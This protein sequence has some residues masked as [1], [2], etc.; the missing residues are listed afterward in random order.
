M[1]EQ[2]AQNIVTEIHHEPTLYAEPIFFIGSFPVTNALLTSW[3]AVA[4]IVIAAVMLRRR[5]ARIPH[6]I[7]NYA[8]VMLEGAL[9]LAD[10]VTTDRR[11]SMQFMPLVFSFFIFILLSNWLGILPGVGSIGFVHNDHGA[12]SLVPLFRGVTADLNTTLALSL[13]AVIATH[14]FG[15]VLVGARHHW[16]RFLN[17]ET[18]LTIPREVFKKKNYTALIVNPINFG[19]GLIEAVGELAKVASLSFRLFGNVFAGE[20]LLGAMAAILAYGLPIPFLMLEILVGL[21]QA[22]IFAMLVLVF[23]TIMSTSHTAEEHS[24]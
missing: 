15:V 13:I 17:V 23:M 1:S 2:V 5:L 16:G 4:I 8:E 21:I 7:Q 11:R 18:L 19:V 24:H 22:L 6:G 10:S 14:I 12:L 3:L 9:S 20:V